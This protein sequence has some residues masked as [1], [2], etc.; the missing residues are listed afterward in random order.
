MSVVFK[1]MYIV[2]YADDFRIFCRTREGAERTMLAV[3]QWLEHRLHLEV[4]PE[5][6]RVIN[7]RKQYSEFL[8]IKMRLKSK[9]KK[10][11]VESHICDKALKRIHL[12]ARNKMREIRCPPKGTTEAQA[13]ISYNAYVIGIHN[14]YRIATDVSRDL[15]QVSFSNQRVAKH[16]GK[17][18]R[19][20][21]KAECS[22]AI[23]ERYGASTQLR[24]IG[25]HPIAPIS[26]VQ[27]KTPMCKRR[28]VQKYTPEGREAIHENLGINVDML[29]QLLQQPLY[30]RSAEYADNRLSLSCAQ[31]GKCAVTGCAFK[32]LTDIHC[33]HKVPK[34]QGG[35]DN[36]QNLILV[37]EDVHILIHA[38]TK[39]TVA[40][41][42]SLLNLSKPQLS[43]LNKLRAEAGNPPIIA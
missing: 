14:Y 17:K 34:E 16:I 42:L 15:R 1:E 22:N 13:I 12:E 43:K 6:T 8:G 28:S 25:N 5:K 39:L 29:Q 23:T 18:L 7:L 3:K 9:K 36:Y 10:L 31:Y 19:K 40:K 41:Y 24:W 21:P 20:A 4:S 26:F 33:H 32:F 37:H 2:R 35:K 30:Q 38:T 27:A 11:V